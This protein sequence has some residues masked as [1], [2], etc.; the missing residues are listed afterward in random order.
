MTKRWAVA[1]GLVLA[2]AAGAPAAIDP[3]FDF[4]GHWTGDGQ[5]GQKPQQGIT[6]DL[7]QQ[8]GTRT[9]SGTVT[10]ED[11]PTFTCTVAGK[12]KPHKMKVKI[13]I[14]CDNGGHLNLHGTL[15]AATQ[16]VSGGYRRIGRH[17]VH[18]GTFTLTK[19]P[20]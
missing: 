10:V 16:T 11:D 20:S 12:Q 19:Q 4:T 8:T 2:V 17:K 14:T 9:F 5:E 1:F 3:A 15:D 6:A 13:R 7:T 18:V